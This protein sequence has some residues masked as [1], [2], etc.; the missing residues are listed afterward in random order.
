MSDDSK[1][2]ARAVE[3]HLDQ[4]TPEEVELLAGI[5]DALVH[6]EHPVVIGAQRKALERIGRK[7]QAHKPKEDA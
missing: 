1:P 3:L 2:M 4:L 6:R 5:C 7:L